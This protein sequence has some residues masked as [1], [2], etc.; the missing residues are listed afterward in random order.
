MTTANPL[1]TLPETPDAY[2]VPCPRCHAA[3]GDYCI[4][5]TGGVRQQV[6]PRRVAAARNAGMAHSDAPTQRSDKS[7]FRGGLKVAPL[8]IRERGGLYPRR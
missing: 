3:P 5:R 6:H 1:F 7:R 8:D 2:S 4:A